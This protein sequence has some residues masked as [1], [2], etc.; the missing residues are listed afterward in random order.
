MTF[1]DQIGGFG[2]DVIDT[3][4]DIV[5][6]YGTNVQAAAQQRLANVETQRA[7]IQL[8]TAKLASEQ[9]RA[10]RRQQLFETVAYSVL[11]MVGASLIFYFIYK[12]NR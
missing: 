2:G 8:A 4:G 9:E 5:N 11:A 10:N 12:Y 7:N 3:A 1:W 6:A